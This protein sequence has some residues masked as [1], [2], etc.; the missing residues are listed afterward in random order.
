MSPQ[1]NVGGDSTSSPTGGS[2]GSVRSAL[3]DAANEARRRRRLLR[4]ALIGLGGALA[5]LGALLLGS[6]R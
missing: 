3:Q 5:V 1:P 6:P 2:S 4:W